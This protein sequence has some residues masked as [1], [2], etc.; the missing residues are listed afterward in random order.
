MSSRRSRTATCANL[1]YGDATRACDP[2]ASAEDLAARLA[3][4]AGQPPGLARHA[5]VAA[6]IDASELVQGLTDDA[7]AERD[8]R[9]AV[10]DA[11]MR[12]LVALAAAVDAS[13]SSD[14]VR[15]DG[16]PAVAAL[17]QLT[18]RAL[19]PAITARRA[20][21]HA[22]YALYPEANISIHVL[23]GLKQQNT[24]FAV[25][26]S[27]LNRRSEI[28]IGDLLLEYG[29]GGHD[30]AGTCQIANESAERVLAE[31]VERFRS[32]P[33]LAQI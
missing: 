7:C 24:V 6:L 4:I 29:G 31:L 18:A 3:A 28:K 11:G 16:G 1:V 27:I 8:A 23:W 13:W 2:R 17:G 26:K 15:G 33:E 20:E 19:P 30:A 14:F 9:T 12:V 32:A 25:G 22:F 21:A 5:L 10:G